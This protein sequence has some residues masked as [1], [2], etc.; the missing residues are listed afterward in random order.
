MII[1]RARA[2]ATACGTGSNRI[3]KDSTSLG[4]STKSL[5]FAVGFFF[6]CDLELRAVDFFFF[7]TLLDDLLT[8]LERVAR[9]LL[10]ERVDELEDFVR[11]AFFF[12]IG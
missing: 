3:F 7:T 1:I 5:S 12:A 9:L 8:L 10:V 6:V 4:N 2:T 11:F